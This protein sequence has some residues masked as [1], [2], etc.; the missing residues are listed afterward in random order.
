MQLSL[1]DI[2]VM[3]FLDNSSN[4]RIKKELAMNIYSLVNA[5]YP[6]DHLLGNRFSLLD[7]YGCCK[8]MLGSIVKFKLARKIHATLWPSI[9]WI[10]LALTLI[11]LKVAAITTIIMFSAWIETYIATPPIQVWP[12]VDHSGLNIIV[13]FQ[14]HTVNRWLESQTSTGSIP[15]C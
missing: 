3:R 11:L 5:V 6:V 4:S 10:R 15:G 14:N 7:S 8:V 2:T 13:G 1:R 12:T 9:I